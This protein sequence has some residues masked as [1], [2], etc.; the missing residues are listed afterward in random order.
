M[1]KNEKVVCRDC[2]YTVYW[3]DQVVEGQI[4]LI[5]HLGFISDFSLSLHLLLCL[6]L[7]S[8]SSLESGEKCTNVYNICSDGQE[9]D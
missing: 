5:M 4:N 8:V 2:K 7:G 6:M 9:N 3:G 1:Q